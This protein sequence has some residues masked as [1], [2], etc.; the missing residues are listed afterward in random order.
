VFDFEDVISIDI[1]FFVRVHGQK[2]V[3]VV[4]NIDSVRFILFIGHVL[5]VILEEDEEVI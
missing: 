4:I 5:F 2:D 3:D 1:E